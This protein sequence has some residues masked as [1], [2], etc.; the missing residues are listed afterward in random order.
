MDIATMRGFRIKFFSERGFKLMRPLFRVFWFGWK[1]Y[2]PQDGSI[3]RRRYPDLTHD[4]LGLR[5]VNWCGAGA[6]PTG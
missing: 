3:F 5:D 4:Q 1:T 6:P 2:Y